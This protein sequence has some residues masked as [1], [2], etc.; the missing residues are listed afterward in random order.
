MVQTAKVLLGMIIRLIQISGNG[1]QGDIIVS[2]SASGILYFSKA[3]DE[4]QQNDLAFWITQEADQRRLGVQLGSNIAPWITEMYEKL[5][6]DIRMD[7]KHL[8]FHLS[9]SAYYCNCDKLFAPIYY[10]KSGD[11]FC[12]MGVKLTCSR[13][14]DVQDFFVEAMRNPVI[15]YIRFDFALSFASAN[16]FTEYTIRADDFCRAINTGFREQ[17]TENPA[18]RLIIV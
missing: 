7:G 13:L 11:R 17:D 18:I 10:E 8:V 6:Q 2:Y 5:G 1:K 16:E 14:P 3:L 15:A 4:E 9:E 12:V